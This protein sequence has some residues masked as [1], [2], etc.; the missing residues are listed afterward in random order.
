[1]LVGSI[2]TNLIIF[3]CTTKW[4]LNIQP[5]NECTEY[6]RDHHLGRAADAWSAGPPSR[7]LRLFST[8]LATACSR[9]M[10]SGT[11]FSP[12]AL[13]MS[14]INGGSGTYGDQPSEWTE[15]NIINS[16]SDIIQ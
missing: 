7:A 5:I 6:N 2:N 3:L 14:T 10:E 12:C 9:A 4:N 15:G 11:T 13:R 1:M 8:P 16:G